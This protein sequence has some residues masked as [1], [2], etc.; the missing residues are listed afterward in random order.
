M[1]TQI[2][3]QELIKL[4]NQRLNVSIDF[5]DVKSFRDC[6]RNEADALY[7]YFLD[8]DD[9]ESNLRNNVLS[10]NA[11]CSKKIAIALHN[12]LHNSDVCEEVC[13]NGGEDFDVD[14]VMNN[15]QEQI[16]IML[17]SINDINEIV[18]TIKKINLEYK[19]VINL[20]YDDENGFDESI[21]IEIDR[22]GSIK[23]EGR[24]SII[25]DEQ[26]E[27]A[28]SLTYLLNSF[29]QSQL[30][31]FE[32]LNL[33]IYLE[34]TKDQEKKGEQTG[35][36]LLLQ[37]RYGSLKNLFD[38]KT[39]VL[40]LLEKYPII[41]EAAPSSIWE[42][43]EIVKAFIQSNNKLLEK[44]ENA[45]VVAEKNNLIT[46][47]SVI[48]RNVKR[49]RENGCV[50][51]VIPGIKAQFKDKEILLMLLNSCMRGWISLDDDNYCE[52]TDDEI[53]FV[54]PSFIFEIYEYWVKILSRN[55][56][57]AKKI[58]EHIKEK[59]QLRQ[60]TSPSDLAAYRCLEM[61]L[62][63]DNKNPIISNMAFHDEMYKV[64]E[65]EFKNFKREFQEKLIHFSIPL[66]EFIKNDLS[67]G[68]VLV[69]Y[70]IENCE[71]PAAF[72]SD[73]TILV[74]KLEPLD[75]EVKDLCEECG[76]CEIRKWRIE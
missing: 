26:D 73:E 23:S 60:K 7:N 34:D 39:R 30:N 44:Q 3:V 52:K 2:T 15:K 38:D 65:A 24:F 54:N 69:D 35:K 27:F 53:L 46:P 70:V 72:L 13:I 20:Q 5:K 47:S 1:K 49:D 18:E 76:L 6:M 22:D 19:E 59:Y 56:K 32:K 29:S 58:S 42:D 9:F 31:V 41:M 14:K 45:F 4:V 11:I 51:K 66:I 75:K 63:H 12:H 28:G 48:K 25:D 36:D 43:K 62:D 8:Y 16:E 17:Y 67:P 57:E 64:L 68:D 21:S 55:T 40:Q 10:I 74:R 37:I 71:Y 33:K 50:N 61:G